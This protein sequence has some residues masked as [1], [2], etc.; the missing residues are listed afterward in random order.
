MR[1]CVRRVCVSA[2]AMLMATRNQAQSD[3]EAELS[4]IVCRVMNEK[5]EAG[6]ACVG[7]ASVTHTDRFGRVRTNVFAPFTTV[8]Q[9]ETLAKTLTETFACLS[10]DMIG[11]HTAGHVVIDWHLETSPLKRAHQGATSGTIAVLPNVDDTTRIQDEETK[12]DAEGDDPARTRKRAPDASSDSAASPVLVAG[13]QPSRLILRAKRHRRS[14]DPSRDGV[15]GRAFRYVVSAF[16]MFLPPAA[17]V[18]QP[19]SVP[20]VRHSKRHRASDTASGVA[21][22]ALKEESARISS[23]TEQLSGALDSCNVLARHRGAVIRICDDVYRALTSSTS[24]ATNI[25]VRVM[26][27]P[28]NEHASSP[29]SMCACYAVRCVHPALLVTLDEACSVLDR[30]RAAFASEGRVELQLGIGDVSVA[31]APSS[32]PLHFRV[33]VK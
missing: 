20:E 32:C 8:I 9:L 13:Q 18:P 30:S 21:N 31:I 28:V 19:I 6:V 2:M 22:E 23:L 7:P 4:R 11:W 33:P 3:T 29:A 17:S 16:G 1:V 15:V 10:L 25:G 12:A 24:S 5:S 14:P 27:A 26:L